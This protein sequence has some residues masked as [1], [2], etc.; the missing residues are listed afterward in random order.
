[1]TATWGPDD[2]EVTVQVVCVPTCARLLLPPR[3]APR[4]LPVPVL[5]SHSLEEAEG[6]PGLLWGCSWASADLQAGHLVSTLSSLRLCASL[7]PPPSREAWSLRQGWGWGCPLLPY[8][9][10]E[11]LCMVPRWEVSH[12]KHALGK[13]GQTCRGGAGSGGWDCHHMAALGSLAG[14][15]GCSVGGT[16]SGSF[17]LACFQRDLMEAYQPAFRV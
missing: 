7:V 13:N 2:N 16:V 14:W 1:M 9:S 15:R 17:I 4:S 10:P 3:D 5:S 12:G 8:H 6:L 11:A